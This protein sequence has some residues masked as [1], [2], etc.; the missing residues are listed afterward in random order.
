MAEDGE[1]YFGMKLNPT[2]SKIFE[3]TDQIEFLGYKFNGHEIRLSTGDLFKK[4][5]YCESPPKD[6]DVSMTRALAYFKLGGVHDSFYCRYIDFIRK[7]FPETNNACVSLKG[8]LKR[9]MDALG[10]TLLKD[11]EKVT[12]YFE[13]TLFHSYNIVGHSIKGGILI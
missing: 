12:D 1:Y 2:K 4:L 7:E 6:L 8:N 5:L 11:G 10:I 9:K 3:K 13:D